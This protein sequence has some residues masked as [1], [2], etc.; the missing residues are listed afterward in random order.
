MRAMNLAVF[1]LATAGAAACAGRAAT[2]G[3]AGDSGDAAGGGAGD[4][5]DATDAGA[6]GTPCSKMGGVCQPASVENFTCRNV[7][8][9]SYEYRGAQQG[10]C[11]ADS[12]LWCCVRPDV[13]G[14]LP[15]QLGDDGICGPIVC[16]A[17][18]ACFRGRDTESCGAACGGLAAS[19]AGCLP[20]GTITCSS[21]CACIDATKNH[22]GC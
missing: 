9:V 3:S 2:N 18:S 20:C 17:G 7:T 15:A 11:G 5:G 12:S 6:S 14:G 4:S 19:D 22:C 10:L 1:V 16:A 21:G 13:D 8:G